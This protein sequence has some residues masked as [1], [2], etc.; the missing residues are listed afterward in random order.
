MNSVDAARQA[1]KQGILVTLAG[2]SPSDRPTTPPRVGQ[3]VDIALEE[4]WVV[5]LIAYLEDRTPLGEVPRELALAL[6]NDYLR[7]GRKVT[8]VVED[9]A[10]SP[11]GK[12]WVQVRVNCD[13]ALGF[14]YWYGTRFPHLLDFADEP[15]GGGSGE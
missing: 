11:K 7:W 13:G 2:L 6:C 9:A 8:C 12:V 5:P 4:H 3:R 1:L 10:V 15:A 14:D